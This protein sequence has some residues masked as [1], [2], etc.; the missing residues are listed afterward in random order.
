VSLVA[1]PPTVGEKD[2]SLPEF[3]GLAALATAMVALSIDTILPAFPEIRDH[4]GLRPGSASIGLLVTAYLAGFGVGQLPAGLASDRFGRKPVLAVSLVAYL[5]GAIAT[6]L[7]TSLVMMALARFVWGMAGAGPRAIGLAM[8]RD[9]FAGTRMAQVM[10][11]IQ[12]VFFVVPIAAPVVGGV[13]VNWLGWRATMLSPAVFAIVLLLW[14][15]RL[16]ETNPAERRSSEVHVLDSA[17]SVAGHR[18]TQWFVVAL[19][20]MQGC[21]ITYLAVSESVIDKMYGLEHRFVVIF[22]SIS[23]VLGACSL[24]NAR[25]VGRLGVPTML[26][27]LPRIGLAVAGG[28]ALA[29]VA[30]SGKPP[31]AVFVIAATLG[32]AVAS[33]TSTNANAAALGPHATVAGF[34][35]G[36]LGTVSSIT[37]AVVGSLVAYLHSDD[38]TVFAAALS[39][40]LAVGFVAVR[41]GQRAL[42]TTSSAI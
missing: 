8:T 41:S 11:Y 35:A 9:R 14:I 21:I 37:G 25:L 6:V 15:T 18:P 3:V 29:T 28:T 31:F 24:S 33:L 23:L 39:A 38:L 19:G 27:W 12:T 42:A 5:V 30:W 40:S 17:R 1:E 20:A 2:Q 22:A 36:L 26:V 10:S 32:L 13:L 4:L 34:A 7:S 16:R